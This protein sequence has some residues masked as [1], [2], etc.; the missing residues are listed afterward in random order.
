MVL[1]GEW[2]LI[3][4]GRN[5]TDHSA[6]SHLTIHCATVQFTRSANNTANR[7]DTTLCLLV[8]VTTTSPD[9]CLEFV[10]SLSANLKSSSPPSPFCTIQF[11]TLSHGP[12]YSQN[13]IRRLQCF[14]AHHV[15]A[16]LV[17][18]EGRGESFWVSACDKVFAM[19]GTAKS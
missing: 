11:S 18:C 2:I 9:N 13:H 16:M 6:S 12:A 19:V 3:A 5:Y 4:L 7:I 15:L 14:T 8:A 17:G 1:R 10:C